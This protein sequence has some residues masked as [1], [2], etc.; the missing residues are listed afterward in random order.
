MDKFKY[1]K[2]E[3]SLVFCYSEFAHWQMTV[4]TLC[5]HPQY[6]YTNLIDFTAVYFPQAVGLFTHSYVCAVCNE[7]LEDA[8][9]SATL[10]YDG[11][12]YTFH[13]DRYKHIIFRIYRVVK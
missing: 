10:Y 9:T 13:I 8:S 4:H 7:H 5:T 12:L 1:K 2:L 3:D 6:K 11:R